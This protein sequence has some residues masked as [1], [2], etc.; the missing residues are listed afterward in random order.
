MIPR[1][2]TEAMRDA[3]S[4]AAR[5][6]RWTEVEIAVC[7]AWH[8]RGEIPDDEMKAI[9]E[10]RP[11]DAERVREIEETTHHDVVA[12]VRAL[13][14]RVGEPASRHL[15]RGMT[16]SDIIDTALALTLYRSVDVV[17]E[18]AE[19]LRVTIA[20]RAKEFRDVPCVGRTHGIHAEPTTFGLKLAGWHS[21]MRRHHHRLKT[22]RD[23]IAF[24]KLSGAVGNFSQ[25]DP[26]FE[27]FVLERLGLSA[28]PIAT[29]IVPRDRHATVLTTL[30]V[31]GAGLERFATEIRALQKT[32]VREAEEPFRQ[33][34]TGSSAMP[35][36]RNPILT[37]RISGMARL[38]RGYAG[39]AIENVALWHERDISHSSVERVMLPDAFHLTHYMLRTLDNV[40]DGMRVYPDAM[41]RNLEKTGGLVFSQN[42]LGT[43]LAAGLDRQVAYAAVQRAAMKVWE[44]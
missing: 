41:Q 38:L 26:D 14:E 2:E 10:A 4:D 44:G 17:I 42:V 36:K 37:E 25:T 27:A 6:E 7:E 19:S 5:F 20:R 16:S 30:A 34:Q 24:G 31:L 18:A 11:P 33:G 21:E 3:W 1:Y 28:E 9:R 32:E 8:A 40:V 13:G 15:H 39:A 29:Q 12:F 43:L 35:H 23:E 22:A